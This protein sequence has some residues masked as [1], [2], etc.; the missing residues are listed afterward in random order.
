MTI[1]TVLKN[2]NDMRNAQTDKVEEMAYNF[3]RMGMEKALEL[4]GY[5]VNFNVIDGTFK[6]NCIIYKGE[7]ISI[8]TALIWFGWSEIVKA[9]E[10]CDMVALKKTSAIMSKRENSN[11]PNWERKFLETY[12][13][14][15]E[16][17]LVL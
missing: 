2:V 17:G 3:F 5:T 4:M 7:T 11:I 16:L 13:G 6:I 10:L 14:I 15:S 1:E 8:D 12:L 9:M